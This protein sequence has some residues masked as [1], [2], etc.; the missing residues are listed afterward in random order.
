MQHS[1]DPSVFEAS[2]SLIETS[3]DFTRVNEPVGQVAE[4]GGGILCDSAGKFQDGAV[5]IVNGNA[6]DGMR[7]SVGTGS[8]GS[9]SRIENA[10]D[11]TRA[12]EPVGQVAD[13]EVGVF[14]DLASGYRNGAVLIVTGKAVDGTRGPVG[15]NAEKGQWCLSQMRLVMEYPD[16]FY[17]AMLNEKGWLRK[18]YFSLVT[19]CG[20]RSMKYLQKHKLIA[21]HV[22][23]DVEWLEI[24]EAGEG[25]GD[26]ASEVSVV[27]EGLADEV[28]MP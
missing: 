1:A 5:L 12:N 7:G 18:E 6:V 21:T 14:C 22:E 27:F 3:D 17:P 8:E 23:N 26:A 2:D 20:K 24:L 13:M 16:L 28:P 9:D 15:T 25:S 19:L 11:S 10:N 4:T